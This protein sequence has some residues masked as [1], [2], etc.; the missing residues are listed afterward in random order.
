VGVKV[1]IY[2]L[3]KFP[4]D[5]YIDFY[6]VVVAVSLGLVVP[7]LTNMGPIRDLLASTLR[8]SLDTTRK[9]KPDEL[10][11][12]M[13]KIKELGLSPMQL[14]IGIV[15]TVVGFVVYYFVPLSIVNNQQNVLF[16]VL[17]MLLF[18]M[19]MGMIFIGSLLIPTLEGFFL[20]VIL[21]IRRKDQL[22]RPIV[23]K[24]L[25]AHATRNHK[26]SLMFMTT[27]TFLIFCGTGTSQ[28]EYLV[29]SLTSAIA[30]ADIALF[31]ANS[32]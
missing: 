31:I 27:I 10:S 9:G 12:T 28:V 17:L 24:N 3:M 7:Q 19:I 30:N 6:T 21:F 26:S 18:G 2:S 5:T 14:V 25:E 32:V 20:S 29:L 15:F 1:A 8:D 16:M 13:T 4:I 22:L 23:K 11:L